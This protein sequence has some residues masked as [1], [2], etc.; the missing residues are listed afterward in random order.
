LFTLAEKRMPQIIEQSRSG[1]FTGSDRKHLIR[2]VAFLLILLL[3]PVYSASAAHRATTL[4]GQIVAY[5]S[6]LTC[7]NGNAYW[8]MIIRAH[9]SRKQNVEYLRVDFSFPCGDF[10]AFLSGHSRLRKFRLVRTKDADQPLEQ[11][12]GF[13]DSL[14]GKT[15]SNDAGIPAWKATLGMEQEKLP[16]GQVLPSYQSL[17]YPLAP[18][19]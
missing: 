8:S 12:T 14:T 11:F 3:A 6:P 10:P 19:L 4:S 16:F 17:D 1:E 7:I 18:V 2:R 15:H 13:I 9:A 5:S